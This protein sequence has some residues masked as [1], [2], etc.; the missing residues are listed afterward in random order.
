MAVNEMVMTKSEPTLRQGVDPRDTTLKTIL[1]HVQNDGS[2]RQRIEA[3]LSFARAADAHLTCLQVTPIEAY[4]AFDSFGGVFVMDD[5]MKAIDEEVIRLRAEVESQ[6]DGED[7][8]WDYV[9]VTGNVVSEL[10]GHAALADLVV[11]G[12]EP[13]K[14]EL[15]RP[16]VGLLGDLLERSRTPLF[17]PGKSPPDPA[18]TAIIAWDGSYEAANAVRGAVGLLKLAREVRVIQISERA[19]KKD[20]FPSTKLLEYLS[21]QGI[22]AELTLESSKAAADNDFVAASLIAHARA[23]GDAYVVMG[24]YG[25]SRV[26]EYLFGGVTRI[27]LT[28]ASVPLVIM[29]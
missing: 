16:I 4:V 24:G 11:T 10:V 9:Q 19:E 20:S 25:H 29:G 26:R 5:V 18:G 6:L 15:G 27:M 7:V 21:R 1:V 2:A 8:S 13:A 12:R 3:G 14:V 28:E 22:R 17:I 23:V